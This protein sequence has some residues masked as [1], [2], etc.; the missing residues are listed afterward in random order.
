MVAP[1]FLI[2]AIGYLLKRLGIINDNFVTVSSRVVFSIALPALLFS[3]ISIIKFSSVFNIGL[4]FFVYVVTILTFILSWLFSF[5]FVKNK[6]DKGA[7]I[8]GSFRGN[9]AIV[10]LALILSALGK[11]SLAKG[12]IVLAFTIPL[13]NI[14]AVLVLSF[15]SQEDEKPAF[16][17]TL[18]QIITNPLIIAILAALP[19]SY[20]DIRLHPILTDTINYAADLTLP[21]A[22]LGIG[23]FLNFSE[24]KK[25]ST[26]AFISTGLKIIIFPLIG[27][28]AAYLVGYRN[29]ELGITFILFGCPTAIASFVMAEA[30]GSNSRLA[31]NIVLL[32]TLGSI[33]TIS[34][35]LFILK[36]NGLI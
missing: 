8:Q 26:N 23:G 28:L 33:L 31:G 1:V 3:Q 35:G 21:L 15:Y 9:Y 4:I 27:T 2:V 25:A 17:K 32:T 13:Y 5:L 16:S 24:I 34:L 19:F 36:Q 6:K 29:D 22:L 14:L 30:M 18:L 12:S 10:G 7:F 20:L 11:E